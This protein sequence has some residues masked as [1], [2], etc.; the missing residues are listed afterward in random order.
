MALKVPRR[1]PNEGALPNL[2]DLEE[3]QFITNASG[4]V[5]LLDNS[6]YIYS[7][8]KSNKEAT[9]KWWICNTHLKSGCKARATTE[10]SYITKHTN[11]HSHK[12]I[13][14]LEV[15]NNEK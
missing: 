10:G 3:A 11:A 1:A 9:K 13:S 12:P 7:E 14:C 5:Q 8:N 15:W 2:D 6:G 4:Y